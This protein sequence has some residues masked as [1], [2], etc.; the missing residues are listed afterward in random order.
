MFSRCLTPTFSETELP[1]QEPQPSVSDG[2]S[3]KLYRSPKPPWDEGVFTTMR[4]V[5]IRS[6]NSASFS[7]PVIVSR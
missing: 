2:V 7:W 3:A 6:W 5:F 1:P 4:Q